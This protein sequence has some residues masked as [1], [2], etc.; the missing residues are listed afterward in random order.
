MTFQRHQGASPKAALRRRLRH[1]LADVDGA[2]AADA[3][4]QVATRLLATAEL[5]QAGGVF[6]CLSFGDEI[7]TWRLV[8]RL[9]A[10]GKRLYVPRVIRGD[11]TLYVHPYPCRLTTTS[12]GLRQP[13]VTAQQLSPREIPA[14]LDV[15]LVLGLGFD[16]DGFRLGY[17][18]GYFDRFLARYDLTAIGLAYH[19]QLIAKVPRE[20]HDVPMAAV[21]TEQGI[22]RR[23]SDTNSE[24]G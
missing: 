1:Q 19:R 24:H 20:P 6:C 16:R 11:S 3:A 8:E 12:Y 9:S 13:T 10:M 4:S 22:W 18:G 5:E 21:V 15:V 2:Y 7:D 14:C 23:R 17:G